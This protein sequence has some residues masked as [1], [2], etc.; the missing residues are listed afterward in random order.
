M[1]RERLRADD[2]LDETDGHLVLTVPA[3]IPRRGGVRRVE[4]W[5]KSDWTTGT[6]RHDGALIKALTEAHEWRKLIE[7]GEILT[8]EDL[9]ARVRHDRKYVRN[10][11]KLAFL[12]PDIQRAILD[13]RQPRSLTAPALAD[14]NLPMLWS[15]QRSMLS[16]SAS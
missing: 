1:L 7:S 14:L 8:M 10:T 2:T 9:S 16:F 6:V 3:H 5:E 15:E 4:G 13:G 11:L 12:A